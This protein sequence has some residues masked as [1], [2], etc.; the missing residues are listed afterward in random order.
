MATAVLEA[1]GPLPVAV[2]CDD[3]PV[4]DWASSH[5]AR[6][7]WRPGRGLNGAVQDGVHQLH[8]AGFARVIVAH[9]DLPHAVDLTW[10][11]AAEHDTVIL[12]P[13]R[14]D[15]GTNVVSL[16]AGSGFRFAYGAGSFARHRDEA[17]RLGLAVRIER[18]PRLSWDVDTPDDLDAP[19]WPEPVA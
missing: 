19:T 12:V 11:A 13:D 17:E 3:E 7:V 1:A 5:G 15:D 4:A 6:V 18:V 16:P 14:R 10:A 2:V 8:E 9:A